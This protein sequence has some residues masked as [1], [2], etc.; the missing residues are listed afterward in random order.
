M[1]DVATRAPGTRILGRRGLEGAWVCA[2]GGGRGE[3][4]GLEDA[5]W[6]GDGEGE[7][8]D[9]LHAVPRAEACGCLVLSPASRAT[10]DMTCASWLLDTNA[11]ESIG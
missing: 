8:Q 1:S 10:L 6:R 11:A 9:V 3:E 2:E 7:E 4:W 5:A